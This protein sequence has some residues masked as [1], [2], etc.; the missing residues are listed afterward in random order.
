LRKR[1][2][3]VKCA[4]KNETKLGAHNYK[5]LYFTYKKSIMINDRPLD[6]PDGW[7]TTYTPPKIK[8]MLHVNCLGPLL[9][10]EDGFTQQHHNKTNKNMPERLHI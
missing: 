5:V 1:D 4:V 8:T 3:K 2:Q 6:Y 10:C 9:F 7:L